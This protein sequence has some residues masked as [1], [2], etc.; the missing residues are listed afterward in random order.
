RVGWA[1]GVA[2]PGPW[3]PRLTLAE[4]QGFL[5]ADFSP[6]GR[7]LAG[8]SIRTEKR[9]THWAGPIRLWDTA[10]GE[11]RHTLAQDCDHLTPPLGFAP[12]GRWL[13]AGRGGGLP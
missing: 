7:T 4:S 2:R 8:V 10:T 6:D 9:G 1:W 11:V 5:V 12:D 13:A 3:P